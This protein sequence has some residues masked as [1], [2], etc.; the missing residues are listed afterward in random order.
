MRPA[1]L[2]SVPGAR[3]EGCL[4]CSIVAREIPATIVFQDDLTVAFR[5]LSPV[6][7]THVLVVPRRHYVNIVELA[8]SPVDS[9]GLISGIAGA[10]AAEGIQQFRTIF[11][12]GAEVGQ[13]VLHVHA[14]LL[15]GRPFGWPP[16]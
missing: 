16:G 1:S 11:N 5:D 8:S 6:A 3:A 12:T 13:S 7:P 10:A 9:Q 15:A 2:N 14:H 4:F